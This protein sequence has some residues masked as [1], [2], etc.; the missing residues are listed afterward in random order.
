M[1]QQFKEKGNSRMVRILEEAPVTMT[2]PLPPSYDAVRDEAMHSLGI[3]TTRDMKSVVS[4][5][6]LPSWQFREYTLREKVNLWRGKLFSRSHNFNLWDKMQATDLTKQVTELDLPVYFFS[7]IYDYTVNYTMAQEY[8]EKLQA[9]IKGFYTFEQSA[10]SPMFEEPERLQK[11]L[12]E[13]VLIGANSLAD[14]K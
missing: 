5:I 2:V 12:L 4:G 8:F 3:G 1:L 9:P 6:F 14:G 7:G 10:H 11:I 13:D